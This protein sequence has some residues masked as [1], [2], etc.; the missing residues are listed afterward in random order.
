MPESHAQKGG[1]AGMGGGAA[2]IGVFGAAAVLDYT[3][4]HALTPSSSKTSKASKASTPLP[5]APFNGKCGGV[6]GGRQSSLSLSLSLGPRVD[7]PLERE[8]AGFWDAKLWGFGDAKVDAQV[9]ME[10]G[11]FGWVDV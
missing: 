5:P 6:A 1:G 11:G 10:H 8:G 9:F 3:L 4:L 2:Q 7:P